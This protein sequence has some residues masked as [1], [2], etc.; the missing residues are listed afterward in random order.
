MT[1]P[2]ATAPKIS[3]AQADEQT[4]SDEQLKSAEAQASGQAQTSGQAQASGQAQEES[5]QARALAQALNAAGAQ[6]RKRLAR[7]VDLLP[8]Y[9]ALI[10]DKKR[11]VFHNKAFEHFFGKPGT[12]PCH[13][14]MRGKEKPCPQCLMPEARQS[15]EGMV[16]EWLHEAGGNAF[17]VHVFPFEDKGGAPCVLEVGFN[18]T[19]SLRMQQAL[20]L[21]EQSYRAITDNLSIGIALLDGKLRI[22]A[23]NIRLSQWFA[24]GFSKNRRICGLLHCGAEYA[25]A[26]HDLDFS[27]PDCP[28]QASFTDGLS[29]E[30]ELTIT[31]R[32]GSEHVMRLV[33]CPV[34][35]RNVR[36]AKSQVR[37]VIL[38]LED[39]T[40]RL[41]VTQQLQRARKLEAMN[42]LAGGIAHEINQ[43]LSALHL[44]A[45]GLQMLLEKEE[46]LPQETTSQ[47]L[48]LIMAEADKIRSIIS[49]M[50]ALAMQEEPAPLA[51]VSLASAVE[52]ALAILSHQ[53]EM[54]GLRTLV[55]VPASLPLVRANEVQ[56]EQVLVNLLTNAGHAVDS[57]ADK[58]GRAPLVLIRAALLPETGR[59]RLEVAD[60]GPGLPK[61]AE[62]VFDPFFTTKERHEG[63]GLGLSIAHGLV[64]LWGGEISARPRHP[65]LGG[66]TFYLDLLPAAPAEAQALSDGSAPE[67]EPVPGKQAYREAHDGQGHK[68][69]IAPDADKGSHNGT[70][71]STGNSSR[72]S[73]R[74]RSVKKRRE[75]DAP[76]RSGQ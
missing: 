70:G 52:N 55:D 38:M 35:P 25:R 24:E 23:G 64:S 20:D 29:H 47:R 5:L 59:V 43:P 37:A 8:C 46:R 14:L 57:V 26:E 27:C 18:I 76:D 53:F 73:A 3:P 21:S 68:T 71:N 44:Y 39:I 69:P 45:G 61:G 22:K 16:M 36:S 34:K 11:V 6:E 60:S 32:S 7:I 48:S 50:R 63:M 9:V 33:T 66:A 30:K 75:S 19:A 28:F 17:R 58:I 15:Q 4:A 74:A 54:R 49:H 72:R 67:T 41:R 65:D 13:A 12:A 62:R 40:N 51:G 31:L 1:I 10:D 2:P 42:T 56:L